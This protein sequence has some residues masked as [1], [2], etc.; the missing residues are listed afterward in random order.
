MTRIKLNIELKIGAVLVLF[1]AGLSLLSLFWVPFDYNLMDSHQRFLPPGS[2]HFFGTDNFGRDIFSRVMIGGRYTLLLAVCTVAAAAAAGTVLG[3][4]AGYTGGAAG[5][6]T[7][8]IIG[9]SRS[10]EGRCV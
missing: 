3:L 8:R 1:I 5:E 4:F 10:G 7:M 6:I 9:Q 2:V